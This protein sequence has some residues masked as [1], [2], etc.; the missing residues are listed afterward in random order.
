[1]GFDINLETENGEVLVSVGDAKNI[2][3]RVLE[4]CYEDQPHLTEIDW[5]G[6]TTFNRLQMPRFLAE[7]AIVAQHCKNPE[8][9]TLI[10]E[11]NDLA[12]RCAQGVHLYLK[13]VGD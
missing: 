12:E 1:M 7:W 13:F 6:D 8:E 3:R 4:R 2:L 10:A 11:I 5:N 9:T